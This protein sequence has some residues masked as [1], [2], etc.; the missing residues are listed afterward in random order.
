MLSWD[1]AKYRD[2]VTGVYRLHLL[3]AAAVCG[4]DVWA[5]MPGW[6]TL[7]EGGTVATVAVVIGGVNRRAGRQRWPQAR[8]T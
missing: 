6:W 7:A 2:L 8:N 1:V 3:F 4:I 5:G